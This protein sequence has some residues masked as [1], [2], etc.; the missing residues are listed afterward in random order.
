MVFLGKNK[1]N[2]PTMQLVHAGCFGRKAWDYLP[3]ILWEKP[4]FTA[5]SA[6][7]SIPLLMNS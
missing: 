4:Y 6:L 7:K 2:S 3:T 1:K 5:S